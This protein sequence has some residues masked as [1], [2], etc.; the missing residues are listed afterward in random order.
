MHFELF[1]TAREY[2]SYRNSN[3]LDIFKKR[4]QYKPFEYPELAEFRLA[5]L[6]NFWLHT[7]YNYNPDI[8]DLLINMPAAD[9]TTAKRAILAISQIEVKVK[10][11]WGR[12]GTYLPKPEIEEVGAVF[13]ANEVIHAMAYSNLL[14]VMNLNDEFATLLEVPAIKRRVQYLERSIIT[15]VEN[16][17][18]LLNILLFSMFIENVSL[19]SQFYILLKYYKEN[20]WLKGTSNAIRATST[21]ETLHGK[22]GFTLVNTIKAE[23]PE[24][25]TPNLVSRIYSAAEDALEAESEVL[26]WI[27][28]GNSSLYSETYNFILSRMNQS[29][30]EIGLEP[31]YNVDPFYDFSW[32]NLMV[33]S[34]NAV[35]FFDTKSTAY[36][37]G[38]Q[39]FDADSLF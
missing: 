22:F 3:K 35:D 34:N 12:I 13:A 16:A 30:I 37:K 26:E 31:V 19:F 15:P 5:I 29:L 25:W 24:W 33:A 10:N 17:D 6:N 28:N 9:A 38:T 39:S 7:H 32:F 8:Q 1:D 14:E 2:I 23:H 18:Y 4:T 27:V 20:K 11:F 21:E 36:T